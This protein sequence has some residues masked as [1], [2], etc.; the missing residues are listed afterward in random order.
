MLEAP[1]D[2]ESVWKTVPFFKNLESSLQLVAQNQVWVRDENL[3]VELNG[4]VDLLRDADGV[5]LF[6]SLSSLRGAYRFQNRDFRI[7]LGQIDFVGSGTIDPTVSIVG[8]TRLP[9]V[10]DPALPSERDDLTIRVIVGG[11]ITQPEIT[12]ESDPP[13]GDEATILSYI[14]LGPMTFLSGQQGVFGEQ[15]A[16]LVVGLAANQLKERIGQ[17]LNL[18][19]LQLENGHGRACI[20]CAGWEVH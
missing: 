20:P 13:V 2:P 17:E 9:I 19:V 14:L 10:Q 8:A 3:N 18:D 16:G 12:L 4:D 5:R 1:A 7:E 15:S 6:G 11:T